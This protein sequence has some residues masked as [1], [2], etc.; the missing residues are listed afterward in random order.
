MIS[1]NTGRIMNW[2]DLKTDTIS[3]AITYPDS[4]SLVFA[5][6]KRPG[7]GYKNHE[8]GQE[9]YI[10][11]R[12]DLVD[13]LQPYL[14]LYGDNKNPFYIILK[15][16]LN[17]GEERDF[18][19]CPAPIARLFKDPLPE[20]EI[21]IKT[22]CQLVTSY[23]TFIIGAWGC[24]FFGNKFEDVVSLFHKYAINETVIMAVP[25][26]NSPSLTKFNFIANTK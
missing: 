26:R 16:K 25:D 12:T 17:T 1:L 14:H 5:S 9:E 24:G 6:H 18:I 22:M 20:L 11:R 21:R 23:K 3:A 7:G 15:L 2:I 4:I 13:K 10:A 19:C 8:K